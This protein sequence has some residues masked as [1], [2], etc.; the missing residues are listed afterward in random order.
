MAFTVDVPIYPRP[1]AAKHRFIISR[2]NLE[3]VVVL[4]SPSGK[5]C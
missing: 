1:I 5:R 2:R 4:L 3:F